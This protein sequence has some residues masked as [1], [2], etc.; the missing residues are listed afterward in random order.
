MDKAMLSLACAW[1]LWGY[2]LDESTQ[3]YKT[4]LPLEGFEASVEL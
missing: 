4:P 1:V 3:K 2:V